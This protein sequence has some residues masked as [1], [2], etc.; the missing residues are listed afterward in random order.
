L[1]AEVSDTVLRQAADFRDRALEDSDAYRLVERLAVE[2]GPRF[3][4]TEGDRNAVAWA[5]E[6]M[7]AIGFDTVRTQSVRVPRW[8]RGTLEARVVTPYPQPLVALALGGSVGTPESGITAPVVRVETLAD[9]EEL[10]ESDVAGRIV[11]IDSMTRRSRDATGY[12]ETRPSRSQGPA[13][14]SRKGA[15]A[16]VVRSVGTSTSRLAHTGGTYFPKDVTPIPSAA[17]SPADADMLATQVRTGETV[18][19]HL[20]MSSRSLPDAVSANVV[21]EIRGTRAADEIVLLGAHLD[22]WDVGTGAVDDGTGVAIVLEAA[23]LIISSRQRPERTIRVVLFAN[24]EFGLT[25][26]RAY[27]EAAAAEEARHVLGMESD[28]GGGRVWRLDSGVGE[29]GLDT[30]AVIA[31][32]TASVGA[33]AGNNKASGGADLKYLREAGMPILAPRHDASRYFDVHHTIA[34]TLDKVNA[35]ELRQSVAVFLTAAW[36]AANTTTDFGR[37]PDA[38]RETP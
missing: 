28:L 26:A 6:T 27:A 36:V 35:F 37:F 3:A 38:R 23:R 31:G 13:A 19:L 24:E 10:P 16:A 1:S 5:V 21:G 17:L 12:V 7:R 15:V 34:D 20:K 8:E 30:V 4:G 14:A 18:Q 9:L 2:V 11:F 25:G 33:P 32:L 29:S 22:S